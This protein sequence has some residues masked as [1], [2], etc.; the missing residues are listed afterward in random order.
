MSNTMITIIVICVV[1]VIA[2]VYPLMAMGQ[3]RDNM[4]ELE[5]QAILADFVARVGQTGEITRADYDRLIQTLNVGNRFD[6]EIE[7]RHMDE[8]P[9][10]RAVLTTPDA[11][12]ENLVFSVFTSAIENFLIDHT[13][14]QLLRGD[15]VIVSVTNTNRTIGQIVGDFFSFGSNSANYRIS[16]LESGLVVT[17]GRN[18]SRIAN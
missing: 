15:V 18:F 3:N 7:V 14:Y 10:K 17:N 9:A 1:A 13:H 8:H 5:V 4:S 16:A 6:V 12:G 11:M 2:V